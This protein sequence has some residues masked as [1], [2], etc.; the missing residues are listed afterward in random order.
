M[1]AAESSLRSWI[2]EIAT[3]WLPARSNDQSRIHFPLGRLIVRRGSVV[4]DLRRY[5]I[6]TVFGL[7]SDFEAFRGAGRRGRQS[8]RVTQ[9]YLLGTLRDAIPTYSLGNP[10]HHLHVALG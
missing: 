8:G 1:E 4:Q 7:G 6:I 9:V 5:W 10:A 2:L 3:C